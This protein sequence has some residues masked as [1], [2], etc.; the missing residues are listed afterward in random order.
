MFIFKALKWFGKAYLQ[1]F[2]FCVGVAAAI[3]V[4]MTFIAYP[5]QFLTALVVGFILYAMFVF[6]FN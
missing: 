2:L 3:G 5:V 4:L 1:T 6:V